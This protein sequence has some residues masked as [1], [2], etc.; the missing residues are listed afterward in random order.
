MEGSPLFYSLDTRAHI[1]YVIPF[2]PDLKIRVPGGYG[3]YRFGALRKLID[4]ENAPDLAR[5]TASSV[6]SS[7]TQFYFYPPEVNISYGASLPPTPPLPTFKQIFFY[8]SNASALN[9]LYLF[10]E[11][12]KKKKNE[13][14]A[15]DQYKKVQVK[16][17]ATLSEG[18]FADR[19][20]GFFYHRSYREEKKTVQII[21][22]SYGAAD[23][24]GRVIEG[25]GIR[26]VDLAAGRRRQQCRV[27]EEGTSH[28][29][30]ARDIASFL[31]CD[32]EHGDGSISDII[33]YLGD[34]V[35]K[36]WASN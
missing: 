2:Y 4:L 35:E 19:Y 36:E 25:N 12:L 1:T 15:L 28:S 33:V 9:R 24:L 14:V 23:I 3:A 10:L 29:L 34:R 31:G 8:H 18:E 16:G 13:Y 27:T 21:Y 5:R 32:L 7:F 30:S 22:T 11:L 17:G 20:Q 26:V 6:T